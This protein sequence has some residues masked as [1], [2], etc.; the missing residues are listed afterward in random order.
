[1]HFN[2]KNEFS[3]KKNR[4]PSS[5]KVFVGDIDEEDE[6]SEFYRKYRNC[7]VTKADI[8]LQFYHKK[9]DTKLVDLSKERYKIIHRMNYQKKLFAKKQLLKARSLPGL[10]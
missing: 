6:D 3:D 7:Y 5:R 1:M 4:N 9:L 8:E 10:K 2:I